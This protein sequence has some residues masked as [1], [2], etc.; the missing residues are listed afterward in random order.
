MKRI[1]FIL[2]EERYILEELRGR[3]KGIIFIKIYFTTWNVLLLI[4]FSLQKPP[5]FHFIFVGGEL[6]P[7]PFVNMSAKSRFLPLPLKRFGIKK[8]VENHPAVRR[9]HYFTLKIRTNTTDLG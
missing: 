1:I 7:P 9:Y 6:T 2:N 3:C 8:Y 5:T 4:F